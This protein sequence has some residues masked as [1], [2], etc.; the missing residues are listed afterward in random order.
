[1]RNAIVN[2]TSKNLKIP[3]APKYCK[4]GDTCCHRR[5]GVSEEQQDHR[6]IEDIQ[7]HRI[8]DKLHEG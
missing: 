4:W 1:M 8:I 5:R 6:D 3:A 2:D 7:D